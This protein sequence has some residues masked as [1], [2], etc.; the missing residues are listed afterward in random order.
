MATRAEPGETVLLVDDTQH[1]QEIIEENL[2][3]LGYNVLVASKGEEALRILAEHPG[4]IR[5]LLTDIIMP[6]IYGPELA[7]RIATT[8][9]EIRVIFMSGSGPHA[10]SDPG[11]LEAGGAVL[12][13]PFSLEQLSKAVRDR[14]TG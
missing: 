12:E 13:K 4:P 7:R 1:L 6:G 5:L 14:L 2:R 10:M 8:H 3:D 9:P 11:V